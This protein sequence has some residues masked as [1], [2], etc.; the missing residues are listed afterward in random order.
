MKEIPL[1]GRLIAEEVG[2]GTAKEDAA[3]QVCEKLRGP[4]SELAGSEGFRS[5]MSRALTLA[6]AEVPWLAA[7]QVN[8]DGSLERPTGAEKKKAM[9]EAAK[10]GAALLAQVLGLF[11]TFI[12]ESLTL[13]ILQHIWPGVTT[14]LLNSR[15]EEK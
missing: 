5:I 8:K 9:E 13:H 10:G 1:A 15:T 12:G 2:C 11:I 7:V 4:L 6:K 14:E 3:W